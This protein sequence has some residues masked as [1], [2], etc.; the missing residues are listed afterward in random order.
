MHFAMNLDQT[1]LE[2]EVVEV[3]VERRVWVEEEGERRVWV[4]SAGRWQ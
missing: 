2:V 1:H 4:K 3:V